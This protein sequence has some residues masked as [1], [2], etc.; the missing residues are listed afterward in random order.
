MTKRKQSWTE[1]VSHSSHGVQGQCPVVTMMTYSA[2]QSLTAV[3]ATW[4]GCSSI[5][6]GWYV[7]LVRL[8]WLPG[9]QALFKPCLFAKSASSSFHEL[10]KSS[11]IPEK[12]NAVACNQ[13]VWLAHH[14]SPC[15]PCLTPVTAFFVD[16]A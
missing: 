5:Q 14:S 2:K 12:S 6:H 15:E 8:L 7:V 4:H 3:G 1:L 10:Q 13:R 16:P 11:F 9:F